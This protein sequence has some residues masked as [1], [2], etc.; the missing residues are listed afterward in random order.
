MIEIQPRNSSAA[1]VI[2]S[3][4]VQI[5]QITR[6]LSRVRIRPARFK[7]SSDY[8]LTVHHEGGGITAYRVSQQGT[9]SHDL[10]ASAIQDVFVPEVPLPPELLPKW[11]K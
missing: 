3:D 7:V 1:S 2:V 9:L 11:T 6:S 10:P 4:P 8:R 5:A